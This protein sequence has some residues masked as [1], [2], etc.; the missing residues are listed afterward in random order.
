MVAISTDG[1]ILRY[2]IFP[3]RKKEKCKINRLVAFTRVECYR[4]EFR[5]EKRIK[6]E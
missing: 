6:E 5:P 2:I 3:P 1:Y 4:T